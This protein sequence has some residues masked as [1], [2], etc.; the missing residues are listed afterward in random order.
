LLVAFVLAPTDGAPVEAGPLNLLRLLLLSLLLL[1]LR[2]WLLLLAVVVVVDYEGNSVLDGDEKL[3]GANRP[4]GGSGVAA[5][6]P[7]QSA[8]VRPLEWVRVDETV[9][10]EVD[11][12]RL[13]DGRISHRRLAEVQRARLALNLMASAALARSSWP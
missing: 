12:L 2:L 6:A 13:P 5:A 3:A 7:P 1:L 8:G 4:D 11:V 9:P 10:G